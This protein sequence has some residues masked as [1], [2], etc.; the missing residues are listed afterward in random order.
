MRPSPAPYVALFASEEAA[1]KAAASYK[2]KGTVEVRKAADGWRLV[3]TPP[4][5]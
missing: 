2:G 4:V 3:I 1:L 5:K